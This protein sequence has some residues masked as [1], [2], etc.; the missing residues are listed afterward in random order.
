MIIDLIVLV[1]VGLGFYNGFKRGLISTV[2]DTLS[3]LVAVVATLKLS[4]IMIGWVQRLISN[5]AVAFVIGFLLTFLLVMGII[6]FVGDKLTDVAKAVNL[7]SI[8]KLLGGV[9]MGLFVAVL[10]S[11]A[12]YFGEKSKL[13]PESTIANSNTYELL[14]PLPEASKSMLAKTKPIFS[15]FWEKM[16]ETFDSIKEKGVELEG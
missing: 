15:G 13:I 11:F 1:L 10:M 2:F 5:D 14:Q 3:I 6:R 7:D 16:M 4:P 12:V 9:L 8:N